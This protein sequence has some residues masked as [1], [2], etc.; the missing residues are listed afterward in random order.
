MGGHHVCLATNR[1]QNAPVAEDENKEYSEVEG[2]NVP[3]PVAQISRLTVEDK[4]RQSQIDPRDALSN[5][6]LVAHRGVINWPKFCRSNIDGGSRSVSRNCRAAGLLKKAIM[7][8][9]P[10]S[11]AVVGN[12]DATATIVPAIHVKAIAAHITHLFSFFL[13]QTA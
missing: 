7:R 12:T 11:T 2:Q 1:H 3:D 13:A 10:S 9:F 6:H 5:A 8:H 4:Y